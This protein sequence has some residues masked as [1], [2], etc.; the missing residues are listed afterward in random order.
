MSN[1][2]F[3]SINLTKRLCV[4]TF[5]TI[6]IV[7]LFI[8]SPLNQ[9]VMSSALMKMIAIVLL[10]YS[11]YLSLFQANMLQNNKDIVENPQWNQQLTMNLYCSYIFTLFL[12]LLLIFIIKDLVQI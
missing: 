9:F 4:C 3:P 5:I 7:I 6:F 10:S 12:T 2:V 1:N 8:L 11:I